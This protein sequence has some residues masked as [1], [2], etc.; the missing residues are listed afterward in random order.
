MVTVLL[1]AR[2]SEVDFGLRVVLNV[3]DPRALDTLNTRTL[4]SRDEANKKLT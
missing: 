3:V 4:E 2:S 1:T